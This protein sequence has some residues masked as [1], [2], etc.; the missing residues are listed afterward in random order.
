MTSIKKYMTLIVGG[1]IALLLIVVALYFLLRFRAEYDRVQ[2]ELAG[3]ERAISELHRRNPFPSPDN[4]AKVKEDLMTIESYFHTLIRSLEENQVKSQRM[5]RAQFPPMVA[6]T[7]RKLQTLAQTQQVNVPEP[8]EFAFPNY[9]RGF[10]PEERHLP[11]LIVQLRTMDALTRILFEAPITEFVS[12]ERD[13]F[14]NEQTAMDSMPDDFRTRSVRGV[15]APEEQSVGAERVSGV[16]GL[17]SKENFTLSFITTDEGLRAVLNGFAASPLFV[18]VK[19]VDIKNEWATEESNPAQKLM[20]QLIPRGTGTQGSGGTPVFGAAAAARQGGGTDGARE[21]NLPAM[22][23][24]E[25][26][27]VAGREK[28]HVR[29][30]VDVYRFEAAEQ[31]EQR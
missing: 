11:R 14:D 21:A 20:Q 22:Q 4:V 13:V 26:R 2:T 16:P 7:I 8:M 1:G 6:E 24:H 5:E 10:L 23:R 27:I 3:K 28:L 30:H 9:M 29:L 17:Y 19:N 12:I 31:E 18:V 25:D 15:G